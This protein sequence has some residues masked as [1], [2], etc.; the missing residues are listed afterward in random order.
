MAKTDLLAE[1]FQRLRN[2]Q[3]EAAKHADAGAWTLATVGADG[4]PR[5]RTMLIK[6]HGDRELLFFTNTDS[7]KGEDLAGNAEVALCVYWQQLQQQ[8]TVEGRAEPIDPASA[9]EQWAARG[10]E[11]Q[12]AAWASE[13]S[14]P[15]ASREELLQRLGEVRSRFKDRQVARPPHWS[16]YRVH[17]QRIEFWRAGWHRLSERVCYSLSDGQWEVCLL[18]P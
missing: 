10:R 8:I 2:E 6:V 16:G 15:L 13:Q 18:N 1:A 14:R 3:R 12:L 4:R 17:P 11:N 9:D 5:A 7:R